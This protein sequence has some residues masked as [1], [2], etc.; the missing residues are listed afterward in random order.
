MP[1]Y[2]GAQRKTPFLAG[3]RLDQAAGQLM[4]KT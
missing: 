4:G 3:I 1:V 2:P